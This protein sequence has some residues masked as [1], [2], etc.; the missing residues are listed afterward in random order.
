MRK[1]WVSIA[2]MFVLLVIGFE[3]LTSSKYILE[4]VSFS[5]H[6]WKDNIFPSLFPFFV[7]S[8]ILVQYGFVEFVGEIFKKVMNKLFRINSNCAFIF[9]MGIISGFPSSA[10][11]TK[12]LYEQGLITEKEATKVLTFTHFS[13]PLFILGTVSLLF[14]N[15]K[16]VGL[17]ILCC[18]YL[19]NVMI[20]ILFRG[21]H[22][23][24]NEDTKISLTVA[25]DK[26]HNRRIQ[27]TKNFGQIITDALNHTV[28]TLLLILGTIT[29]FLVLTTII[30]QNI[31]LN[32][33]HQGILNGFVEM[34]QGLKYIS[35]LH[36]PLQ[37][38]SALCAMIL[39]FGGFSV[40]M[41]M[42]SI[43]SDTNIKY[44]PFFLARIVHA[45]LAS[46]MVYFLFDIWLSLV[47]L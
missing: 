46:T 35:L 28:S 26:M 32:S 39:S 41:Q 24:P 37:L 12:E 5:F 43:L 38:K 47:S 31:N 13:N 6:I 9:I 7:L 44:L 15:N 2:I 23:S 30:D 1:K 22:P 25:I 11:Y 4:S 17:L 36:I 29:M 14:L 19:S 20:G 3:I 40:H 21:Y 10:K 34:T 18:H 27:N 8:E 42:M 33:F 45:L 16:E